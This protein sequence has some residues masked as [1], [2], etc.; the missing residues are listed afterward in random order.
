M[1]TPFLVVD[2]FYNKEEQDFIWTELDSHKENFVVDEGTANRG[3]ATN[4]NGKS[5]AN[6]SRIYLDELYENK[7]ERS[8]ILHCYQKLF[9]REII[10]KYKEKTLAART[11]ATTNTDWSQVSYYENNNNY[12]KHFDE[13]MHSVLIWFYRKPKRFDGGDL[14]FTDLNETVKCK[15]NRMILFPSYY[16]HKVNKVIM[17][18]QYRNKGLGRFCLTHFF[19]KK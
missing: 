2:N 17:K 11:Y 15:H 5:I 6:L 13:F 1:E 14:I 3:V 12:D 19:S 10:N 4:H 8:S 16:Y 18:E 7:R 9:T